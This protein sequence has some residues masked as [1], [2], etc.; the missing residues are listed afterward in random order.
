MHIYLVRHALTNHN[1]KRFIKDDN[2]DCALSSDGIAQTLALKRTLS[3][4]CFPNR[5]YVAPAK[6]CQQTA[7]LL[8]PRLSR[9]FITAEESREIDKGFERFLKQN[10][11]LGQM[12]AGKWKSIYI[13]TSNPVELS[14]FVYPSGESIN[15]LYKRVIITFKRIIKESYN[16]DILIIGH[17]G[18]LRS[19]VTY[20]LGGKSKTYHTISIEQ[21]T[22]SEIIYERGVFRLARINSK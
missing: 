16:K 13:N 9:H 8:F 12:T 19:I 2:K 1:K 7:S 6:R 11:S 22:Y 14:K 4:C 10:P 20:I 21:G 5:V 18:P 3:R 17:N 15:K